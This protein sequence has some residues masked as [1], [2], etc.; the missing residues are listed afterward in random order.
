MYSFSVCDI[1]ER[2]ED[3]WH[4]PE[5]KSTNI[6]KHERCQCDEPTASGTV[7]RVHDEDGVANCWPT[8]HHNAN[9][10]VFECTR[11]RDQFDIGINDTTEDTEGRKA[12]RCPS[13]KCK[14][15]NVKNVK[16]GD[17]IPDKKVV[18]YDS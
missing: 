16:C 18:W 5:C 12:K 13:C 10:R 14:K 6:M 7:Y 17:T 11:C 3:E 2:E 9:K 8:Y 1:D 15:L 4:C